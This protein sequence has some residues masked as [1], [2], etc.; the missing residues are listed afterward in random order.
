MFDCLRG[1]IEV[2]QVDGRLESRTPFLD[3]D[4][5]QYYMSIDPKLKMY[6]NR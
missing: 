1:P 6:G 3:K 4:F 5:V 2:Y